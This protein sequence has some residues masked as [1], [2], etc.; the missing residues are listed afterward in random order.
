MHREG[1]KHILGIESGRTENAAAVKGLFT[2]L[3]DQVYPDQVYPDASA[4]KV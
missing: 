3:R 1:R 4:C 2:H